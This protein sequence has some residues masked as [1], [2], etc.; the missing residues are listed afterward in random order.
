[1]STEDACSK[2]GH[3]PCV[4]TRIERVKE[5][6]YKHGYED[7]WDDAREEGYEAGYEDATAEAEESRVADVAIGV[8]A[9]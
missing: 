1:M 7:A 8:R 3:T 4:I 9:C 2:C 6:A 5:A